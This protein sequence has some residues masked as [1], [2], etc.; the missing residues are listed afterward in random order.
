MLGK[1]NS[2]SNVTHEFGNL[3]VEVSTLAPVNSAQNLGI[4]VDPDPS[5]KR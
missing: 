1:V 2:R 5:F 3:V 4:S